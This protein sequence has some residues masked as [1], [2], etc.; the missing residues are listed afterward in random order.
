MRERIV[1]PGM[2]S[3]EEEQYIASL[4]PRKLEDFI[5]QKKLTEKLSVSIRAALQRAEPHEHMLLYGPPGLGKTTLAHI[6]AQEMGTK[7]VVSSGP[8]LQRTGDL[9]GI[10]TNLEQGDILL[11][12]EIHRLAAAVEE[13][14]YP[15]MEDFKVDFV[16][17]KGAFARVINVPLK[18]FTL[19]GATT[20]AGLIS[21]PLRDRFGI[22]H[23]LEFYPPEELALI[24]KRSAGILNVNVPDDAAFEVARRSRGTPRIA[25]RLL[26]RVRDYAQVKSQS[27]LTITAVKD[28]L[29]LE[30]IDSQGLDDLDRRLIRMMVEFYNGGPV[31]I[32]SLAATLNEES[33]TIEEMVEPFLLKIGFIKRTSKGRVVGDAAL[34]HLGLSVKGG[35]QQDLL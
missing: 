15:A 3:D 18:K 1:T 13:F 26:R 22:V 2:V 28:S 20:R 14:I 31:G 21:S 7:L 5:G 29:D 9:M 6:L 30:G 33:G 4:R 32:E 35:S 34:K 23:H 11:I 19:V 16:V 25:N 24:V 12:D 10:L 8:T 17:D 27:N